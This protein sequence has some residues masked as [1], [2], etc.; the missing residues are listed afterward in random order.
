[1]TNE[2]TVAALNF[3]QKLTKLSFVICWCHG[4]LFTSKG[5]LRKKHI[6]KWHIPY[7]L[8]PPQKNNCTLG[9]IFMGLA[10]NHLK[11]FMFTFPK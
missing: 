5:R 6:S 3:G 2:D 9:D 4:Q 7:R 1:M 10:H 8:S 11:H